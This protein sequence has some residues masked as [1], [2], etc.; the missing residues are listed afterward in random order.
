LRR[1][2]DEFDLTHLYTSLMSR[3]VMTGAAMAE[4]LGLPLV[5]WEDLHET[6]GIYVEDEQTGQPIGQ[7]GKHRAYFQE[8]YPRLI[9][10][11]SLNEAGWWNRPFEEREQRLARAQRFLR[12]LL[13]RHGQTD[14]RVAV[15]SHGAFYNYFLSA[16]L[17]WPRKDGCWFMLNNAAITRID[18]E[19]RV[20]L[21]YL[22][23]FEHLPREWVT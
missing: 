4:A 14:D 3:A 6:G 9:L 21:V 17:D 2:N 5:A 11:D 1:K 12:D 20:T 15:V 16:L 10:P 13:E 22:N 23:R 8:H 7:P 18:F 19:D